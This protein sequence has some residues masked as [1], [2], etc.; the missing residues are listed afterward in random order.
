[1]KAS[2]NL[3]QFAVLCAVL[4]PAAG[5]KKS[6]E[7]ENGKDAPITGRPSD[8]PVE[9]KVQWKPDNNYSLHLEIAQSS[10]WQMGS[11][12]VNQDSTISQDYALSVTNTPEG[13]RAV[14][15]EI[16]ALAVDVSFG[17]NTVVRFDSLNK[18]TPSE[19]PGVEALDKLIGGHLRFLLGSDN[20]VRDVQGIQELIQ[21]VGTDASGGRAG[22][23]MGMMTSTLQRVYNVEYFKQ[24]MDFTGLPQNPVRIGERWPM[25]KE[26]TVPMV[27]T[28]VINTTNTLKG[29]QVRDGRNCARIEIDGTLSTKSGKVEGMPWGS[30]MQLENGKV[31]GTE[32]FSP[33]IGLP[34]ESS[35]T[36]SYNISGVMPDRGQ[37]RRGTNAPVQTTNAPPIKFSSPSRVTVTTKLTEAAPGAPAPAPKPVVHA[38][39]NSA[40]TNSAEKN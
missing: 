39:T 31:S 1:M 11:R 24:I 38:V 26:I 18:V 2:Q 6:S 37:R 40:A 22:R 33:D 30:S 29:W 32:W 12:P 14:D 15:L 27:G 34:V 7:G 17:D 13:G 4:L 20:K 3:F 28:L 5:C 8:P 23:G 16:Q 36:Q 25:Q 21:R 35:V 10:Q 19:G 9:M